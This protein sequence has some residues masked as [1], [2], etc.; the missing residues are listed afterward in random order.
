MAEVQTLVCPVS[1]NEPSRRITSGLDYARVGMAVAV[2]QRRAGIDLS[3][4]DVFVNIVGGL[5]VREPG[6]DA[7]VCVALASAR[8]GKVLDPKLV[9][10][11]E[12]GLAGEIRR[13]SQ[14]ERREKE[15]RSLGYTTL[16]S[17]R[18]IKEVLGRK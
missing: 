1:G 15:V 16:P 6:I 11:G 10:M 8:T 12:V 5:K 4:H 13:V 7:A 18:D 17:V 3:N 2:L 14:Q 9:F